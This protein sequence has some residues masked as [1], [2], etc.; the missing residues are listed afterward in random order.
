[1]KVDRIIVIKRL[2]DNAGVTF[3]AISIG[4]GISVTRVRQIYFNKKTSHEE[5]SR[6]ATRENR[7]DNHFN[8]I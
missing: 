1:M 6:L 8:T 3:K 7:I 2:R 5:L 4:L